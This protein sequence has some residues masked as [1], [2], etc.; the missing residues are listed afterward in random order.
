[1]GI[2]NRRIGSFSAEL[3]GFGAGKGGFGCLADLL[4]TL[5]LG[6]TTSFA[7][8]FVVG[9]P[10]HLGSDPTSLDE[11]FESFQGAFDML[12][13]TKPHSQNQLP[14]AWDPTSGGRSNSDA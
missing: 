11:L 2:E 14:P 3:L 5:A 8:L 10:L 12:P 4:Q 9:R 1:M 7:G 6:P 13:R